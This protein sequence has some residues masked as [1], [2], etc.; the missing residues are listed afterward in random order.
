M[1]ANRCSRAVC[2]KVLAK[3]EGSNG[4]APVLVPA[5]KKNYKN[6][7]FPV[8]EEGRT[9]HLGTKVRD[10][11]CDCVPSDHTRALLCSAVLRAALISAPASAEVIWGA[12]CATLY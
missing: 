9:Y 5:H 10:T 7:N 12:G 2:S 11:D 8:D 1:V 3:G 6:A 4:R